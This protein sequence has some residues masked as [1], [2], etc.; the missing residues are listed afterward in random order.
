MPFRCSVASR[1]REEDP[2]GT[3]S[4]VRSFLLVENAGPWGTEALRD[5][6]MPEQVREHLL[7]AAALGV[8][9]LLVRRHRGP[10]RPDGLRVFAARA[11]PGSPWLETA[12]LDDQ[13]SLLDL[14]LAALGRGRS[15]GLPRTDRPVLCVCTHGRHDACCAEWGRPTAAALAAAHPEPTWEVSHVGGDRFAANVLVLPAG[16]YYGRVGPEDAATLGAL[17]E[18]GRLWPAL[19]RGRSGFPLPVQAAEVALRRELQETRVDGVRLAG[20]RA[21]Q[22][23]TAVQLTVDH[24]RYEVLVRRRPGD[25]CRLTCRAARD[26]VPASYDVV[27]MGRVEPVTTE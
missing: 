12:V 6:R 5:A 26:H 23:G 17:H 8:R 13:G 10:R 3:A 1:D 4:T 2:A 24:A 7:S 18:E 11:D 22:D 25:P 14:D 19:L 9:V 20:T 21:D 27:R 15:L 16:L